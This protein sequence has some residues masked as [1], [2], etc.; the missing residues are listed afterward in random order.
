MDGFEG[1]MV[2]GRK[3][4]NHLSKQVIYFRLRMKV[5]ILSWVH[6]SWVSADI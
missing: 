5:D 1:S 4:I 6:G 2:R 3:V